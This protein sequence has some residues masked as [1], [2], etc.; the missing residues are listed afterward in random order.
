MYVKEDFF[1]AFDFSNVKHDVFFSKGGFLLENI[2][3]T[4]SVYHI[5]VSPASDN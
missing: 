1:P 4:G 2:E 3:H 5:T